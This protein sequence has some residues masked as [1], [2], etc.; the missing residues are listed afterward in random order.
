[1]T[2]LVARIKRFVPVELKTFANTWV[3]PFNQSRAYSNI[4]RV[5][6][7]TSV[8]D[9]FLH[10]GGEFDTL[11]VAENNLAM[12]FAEPVDV[13][14]KLYFY[15]SLG[16]E[17][18]VITK[19]SSNFNEHIHLNAELSDGSLDLAFYHQ[20]Q[21]GQAEMERAFQLVP[22]LV[23]GCRGYTGYR[24]RSTPNEPYTFVHGNFGGMFRNGSTQSISAQRASHVYTPQFRF[25]SGYRYDFFFHNP[26]N[27]PAKFSLYKNGNEEIDSFVIRGRGFRGA[28][29]DCSEDAL[30]SWKSKFPLG[31]A[32]VFEFPVDT[33]QRSGFDVFHS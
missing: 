33:E 16:E 5:K 9:Y 2:E 6:L 14:H 23:L 24:K 1:M 28:T 19:K 30:I 12:L 26:T 21:Y 15:N 17:V 7:G 22:S 18:E 8:S 10:R 32:I 3:P 20:L 27:R 4:A 13:V 11:F 29:V 31:R 25:E